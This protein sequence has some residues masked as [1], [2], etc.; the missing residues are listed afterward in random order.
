MRHTFSLA[1]FC[2]VIVL[3]NFALFTVGHAQ[4]RVALVIGN[5]R[6]PNLPADRQLTKAVNDA[7]AV[8]GALEKLGF[9]VIL[10]ENLDRPG[11]VDRLFAFT[12]K[13]KPGGTVVFFYAGHGVAISGG[14]YLLPSDVRQAAPGEE[15]R[16]RNMA[17]GEADIIADIQERKAR[18]AVL[19]LDA[20]RDN[21]FRQPGLLRTLGGERGLGRAREAEGVFAIYSAGFGQTAL[22]RLGSNDPS[23]NSV[24]TRVLVPALGRTD[25]HLG[26]MVID[27][28]EEVVRLA[29]TIGH[30]QSPAYYD[31]TRGGR[32][33][34]AADPITVKPPTASGA[35]HVPPKVETGNSAPAAGPSGLVA[36]LTPQSSNSSTGPVPLRKLAPGEIQATFFNGQPLISSTPSNIKF[37]MVFMSDGTVTR[38]PVSRAAGVKGEGIWKL[39]KDGFCTSWKGSEPT[40]F[41]LVNVE[42]NKW[43][44]VRG[45]TT[46]ATW[47]K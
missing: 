29:A 42:E 27:V 11:M 41:T 9:T 15:A 38:E 33:Y 17:I 22:D 12:Q 16:V 2:L 31:Q 10:G 39:S 47:S 25:T 3:S 20:C 36:S 8:G 28:R 30:Q 24:F 34:L 23:P 14:N 35:P 32:I 6:Y 7:R 40:C 5:D 4:D 26:D 46:V 1:R 13:I 45:A 18:V 44:V 37:K 21:P 43:S 19:M